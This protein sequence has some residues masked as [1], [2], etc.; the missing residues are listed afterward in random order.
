MAGRA[1]RMYGK[2]PTVKRNEE[3]G[4][5]EISH[6]EKDSKKAGGDEAI[7]EVGDHEERHSHERMAMHHRHI[8]EHLAL[9]H[10]HE[11]EHAHHEGNKEELH[12]RHEKE[13]SE[14]HSKHHA[15]MKKLH[16]KHEA[17]I[18]ESG[19]HD[20]HK[21]EVDKVRKEKD[22]LDGKETKIEKE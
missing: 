18:G 10:K 17:E 12:A 14:M 4:E 7:K 3:S 8:H 11:V 21:K 16:K 20:E 13:Y 6:I 15:E 9:H 22:G 19:L 1:E 2:S 5:M